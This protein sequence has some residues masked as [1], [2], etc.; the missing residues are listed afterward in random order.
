MLEHFQ[1][2]GPLPR[3]QPSMALDGMLELRTM[4]APRTLV[5]KK[6]HKVKFASLKILTHTQ[7]AGKPRQA[8]F[9]E[10]AIGVRNHCADGRRILSS[11]IIEASADLKN[12]A[13]GRFHAQSAHHP[14]VFSFAGNV[15]DH[16]G[17]G[18]L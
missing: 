15:L 11:G 1:H 3:L 14:L 13:F 9:G 12:L 2:S 7:V 16:H 18:I 4:V 6:F 17:F 10:T 5:R 8:R